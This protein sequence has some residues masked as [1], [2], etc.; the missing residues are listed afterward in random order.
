MKDA[1]QLWKYYILEVKEKDLQVNNSRVRKETIGEG[2][3]IT[4]RMMIKKSCSIM[5]CV[6]TVIIWPLKWK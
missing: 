5:Q 1:Y 6:I 4:P 2:I 3:L